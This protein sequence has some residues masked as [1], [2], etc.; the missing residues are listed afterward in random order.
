MEAAEA[1]VYFVLDF[2]CFEA[3][4]GAKPSKESDK[5]LLNLKLVE[6]LDFEVATVAKGLVRTRAHIWLFWLY[7]YGYFHR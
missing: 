6:N 4:E 2:L 7:G 1:V 3:V 5:V